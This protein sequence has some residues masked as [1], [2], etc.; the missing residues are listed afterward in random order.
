MVQENQEGTRQAKKGPPR[1]LTLLDP[2][3]EIIEPATKSEPQ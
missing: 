3:A 1:A 2:P